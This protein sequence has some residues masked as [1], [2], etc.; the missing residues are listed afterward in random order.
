MAP[1]PPVILTL[2]LLLAAGKTR[3]WLLTIPTLW[4]LASGATAWV[5]GYWP[6]LLMPILALAACVVA[7]L[8]NRSKHY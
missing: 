4:C 5:L 6:G 1:D 3:L 8:G 2:G 7:V